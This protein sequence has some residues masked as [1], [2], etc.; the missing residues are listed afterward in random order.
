MAI[1]AEGT[2]ETVEF[3]G[4]IYKLNLTKGLTYS[5]SMI[6]DPSDSFACAYVFI[7]GNSN[8]LLDDSF[9]AYDMSDNL[10]ITATSD[11][12][13]MLVTDMGLTAGGR[14]AMQLELASLIK[15]KVTD[16]KG[17]AL[18]NVRTLYYAAKKSRK[19]GDNIGETVT[20]S[21][22]RY[23]IAVRPGSYKLFFS[24]AAGAYSPPKYRAE[25]YS[26]RYSIQTAR[27]VRAVAG[28]VKSGVNVKLSPYRAPASDRKIASLPFSQS[29]R[30]TEKSQEVQIGGN[31]Y[32]AR[33]YTVRLYKGRTYEFILKGGKTS[34][35]PILWVTDSSGYE[36][37]G[38][39]SESG[40]KKTAAGSLTVNKTDDYRIMATD[41]ERPSVM[42]FSLKIS[43]AFAPG[44]I[45]GK[46]TNK[47]GHPLGY[48]EVMV[49]KKYG[50]RWISYTSAVTGFDGGYS[51]NG[52]KAGTYKVRF[53]DSLGGG[54][55]GRVK[56]Y[57]KSS[58]NG[59]KTRPK[60]TAVKVYAGGVRSGVDVQY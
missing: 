17:K 44:R 7:D 58:P 30:V 26:N 55:S 4:Y 41:T 32:K 48:F 36:A 54:E 5:L 25:Y 8:M 38:F 56:Y 51:V 59:A 23:T 15:G 27:T 3:R 35:G 14:Y 40:D 31:V 37:G 43:E 20:D 21:R 34:Y 53:S 47:A 2:E 28:K 16:S 19:P 29:S 6:F 49:F 52:L 1:S 45:T 42:N 57:R 12:Y 24:V 60:G 50:K 18:K 10:Y 11:V 22:G 33:V 39:V 9:Y 13:Y 46:V